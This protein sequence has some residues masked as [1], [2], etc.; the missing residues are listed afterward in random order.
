MP[1]LQKQY[2]TYYAVWDIPAKDRLKFNGKRR[3]TKTLKTED[4]KIAQRKAYEQ[5]EVW[6]RQAEGSFWD[7]ARDD[8]PEDGE[9]W[10]VGARCQTNSNHSQRFQQVHILRCTDIRPLSQ[11]SS[12]FLLICLSGF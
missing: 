1:Y 6:R 9:P 11:R 12:T 10:V 5:V 7:R 8:H 4:K 3:L 2:N